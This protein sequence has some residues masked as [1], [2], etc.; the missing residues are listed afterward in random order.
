MICLQLRIDFELFQRVRKIFEI[1]LQSN[2]INFYPEKP[3]G[4]IIEMDLELFNSEQ[5][6]FRVWGLGSGVCCEVY[7]GTKQQY[8]LYTNNLQDLQYV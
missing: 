1:L 6:G 5:K 2:F 4:F 3:Y 7:T 8:V